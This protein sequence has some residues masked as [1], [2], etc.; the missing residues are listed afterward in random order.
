MIKLSNGVELSE[1]TVVSALKKAGI[2]VEP[3]HVF[4]PGDI[5]YHSGNT[6]TPNC[7]RLITKIGGKLIAI[8]LNGLPSGSYNQKD[9]EYHGYK[10]VGKIWDLVKKQQ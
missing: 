7:W 4:S 5:A 1:D 10:Y 3:K 6:T 9:F 2:S 8:G